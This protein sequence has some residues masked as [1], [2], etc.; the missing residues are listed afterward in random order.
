MGASADPGYNQNVKSTIREEV[1]M[2]SIISDLVTRFEKGSLSRRDLVSGLALI[3][4][5][6]TAATA[7]ENVDFKSADIDHVSIHVSD[8]QRSVDFY[9]K[10][11]GFSVKSQEPSRGIIRLG[12]PSKMLVSLNHGAPAG[13][14][15]HFAIGVPRISNEAAQRYL[16]DRGLTP[17]QGDYAGVHVKDPDGIN[18]QISR[19]GDGA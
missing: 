16:K 18:V 2:E 4:A 6:G 12:T 17:L 1:T 10:S 15:D 14:V 3:A 19:S 11:F 5:S 7:Q 13:I 8:L 9:Q